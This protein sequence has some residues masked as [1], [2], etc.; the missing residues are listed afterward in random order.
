MSEDTLSAEE[1]REAAKPAARAVGAGLQT[2]DSI[3]RALRGYDRAGEDDVTPEQCR[4]DL[5][6][7]GV[8]DEIS[9]AVVSNIFYGEEAEVFPS[10]SLVKHDADAVEI[11]GEEWV[12]DRRN[13]DSNA[14]WTVRDGDEVVKLMKFMQ[15]IRIA[16]REGKSVVV[17]RDGSVLY[18]RQKPVE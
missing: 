7:Y 11:D 14:E 9:D 6:F 10:Q 1:V 5:R 4:R 17:K 16:V 18:E 13:S 15:R 8:A 2:R 12:V 3:V